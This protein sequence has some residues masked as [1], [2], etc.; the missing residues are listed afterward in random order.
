MRRAAHR[1]DFTVLRAALLAGLLGLAA[2][3]DGVPQSAPGLAAGDTAGPADAPL[4]AAMSRASG[5]CA[6]GWTGIAL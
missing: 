4:P 5:E 1:R 3:L 6:A 2:L